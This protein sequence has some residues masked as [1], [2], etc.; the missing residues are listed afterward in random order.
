[1]Q[2]D[3]GSGVTPEVTGRPGTQLQTDIPWSANAPYDPNE[4]PAQER[5][6]RP[7]HQSSDGLELV[8]YCVMPLVERLLTVCLPKSITRMPMKAVH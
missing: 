7:V 8:P 4:L 2:G 5:G 3:K 1:M 6:D